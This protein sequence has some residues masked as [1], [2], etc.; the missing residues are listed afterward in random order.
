MTDNVIQLPQ[1]KQMRTGQ[2][3]LAFFVH[4]GRNDHKELLELITAGERGMFGFVIEALY[5]DR[6]KELI[7]EARKRDFDVILDPKTQ[8]M[9]LPGSYSDTLVGLPW[10][11][12]QRHHT[13]ADF[14]GQAGKTRAA[15][16]VD[17]ALRYGF[18]QILGPSH[19]INDPNDPWLRRDITM[20]TWT[21][22]RIQQSGGNLG[23]IYSLAL[24]ISVLRD[25]ARRAAIVA[26]I[27]NSPCDAIWL[28]VE[29]F[30]DDATGEKTVAYIRACRDFHARGL[31]LVADYVGGLPGLG[32][33]AFG[34]VGGIAH[35]VTINQSFSAA[36][37]RRPLKESRGGTG[38]RVYL[39]Q[40]DMLVKREVARQFI[41]SSQRVRSRNVCRDPHCCARG[42]PDMFDRPARHALYQRAR[43][44]EKLSQDPESVRMASYLENVRHVSDEVALAAS[45][46]KVD[47]GFRKKLQEKQKNLGHFRDAMAHLATISS[48]ES[49]AIP[50]LRRPATRGP[51]E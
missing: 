37:W 27:N 41:T 45:F 39:P 7:T 14:D 22:E 9:G 38:R 32:T 4:V 5:V 26:A 13:L 34:A 30:G 15:K 35:G 3:P 24:P 12:S 47:A 33:L 25:D 10:G 42:M 17:F 49:A 50:P 40:L 1:P 43:E 31:P 51:G 19:L 46:D 11:E 48:G 18:T 6:H 23:L 20:M 2:E 36:S 16:I 21:A 29:N 8:Q 28:K 44:I